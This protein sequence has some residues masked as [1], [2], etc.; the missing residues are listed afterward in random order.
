MEPIDHRLLLDALP[1]AVLLIDGAGYVVH[2]NPVAGRLLG[3]APGW[4]R[5]RSLEELGLPIPDAAAEEPI[6]TLRL[7]G[8][9][10]VDVEW[11]VA[12]I[13]PNE[14]ESLTLV[15]LCPIDSRTSRLPSGAAERNAFLAEASVLLASALDEDGVLAGLAKLAVPRLA[16]WCVF[17]MVAEDG[18]ARRV[19]VT[20]EAS[21]PRHRAW[22]RELE[23]RYPLNLAA[24]G[25]PAVQVIRTGRVDLK[26]A[27]PDSFLA[28]AARDENH[29]QILRGLGIASHVIVPLT[30][31]GRILG[32]LTLV[33]AESGRRYG[34]DDLA[35]AED[36]AQRAAL[37]VDNAR[38]YEAEQ[39]ARQ[40][41][42]RAADRTARLQAVTA[43]LA[44]GLTPAEVATAVVVEGVAALGARAGSIALLRDGEEELEIA[45]FAGY[46]NELID[47]WR[48]FP[49][50]AP[51]PIAEAVRTGNAVWI[52]SLDDLARR[53][54]NLVAS[55]A[56]TEDQ[57]RAAI[58][59]MIDG[60]IIGAMGLSFSTVR[61]FDGDDRAFALTLA[62]QCAQGL[63]RARLYEVEQRA[64][65]AA[66]AAE[67]Q[68]LLLAEASTL[69]A[70][71]LDYETTLTRVAGLVVPR[72]ADW[73]GIHI[74]EEDGSLSRLAVAHV[75]PTKVAWA[76]ELQERYP[77]DLDAPSGFGAV[78]RNG[79]SEVYRE[80]SDAMLVATARD[81]EHLAMLRRIGFRSVMIVPLVTRGRT[82]GVMTLVS[83]ESG[84]LFDP[85]DLALAEALAHRAAQAVD[86]ARLYRQARAA[87]QRQEEVLAQLDTFLATA[88]IGLAF[89]DRDRRFVRVNDALAAMNGLPATAHLG[90]PIGEVLPSLA[91]TLDTVIAAVLTTGEPATDILT[92]SEMAGS[93]WESGHWLASYYPVRSDQGG[94]EILGVG[95][96]VTDVTQRKREEDAVR[97]MAEAST[98][99]AG[100]LD[101]ATTLHSIARLAV[102]HLADWCIV[103]MLEADGSIRRVEVAAADPTGSADA[104][105]LA[106]HPPAL[107][108]NAGVAKVL[109]TG[110]PEL[111]PEVPEAFLHEV[112]RDADHLAVLRRVGFRSYMGVPLVARGRIL[113]ALNFISTRPGR[114]Y[115]P[116]DLALA[117]D[118][119]RRAA[120][121]VDNARL[122]QEQ[123]HALRRVEELAAERALVLGQIADGVI[124]TDSAGRI[125]FVNEAARHIHGLAVLGVPVEEY[126]ETYHLL[127]P[128]GHPY[129][130]EELP[131]AR[132]VRRG[133]TTVGAEWRIHRPDRT[134][135]IAEGSAAPVVTEDGTQLG[136][137]L[138][139]R[140][141]TAQREFERQKDDFV[142]TA[143]HDLKTPLTTIKGWAQ[144]L[145]HRLER[146]PS[147]VKDANAVAA[148]RDQ[149]EAMQHLIEQLLAAARLQIGQQP[150][151]HRR[152][153]D[154]HHLAVR[155]V[156]QHQP[157]TDR[158]TLRVV[159]PGPG[160]VVGWWDPD[161]VSQIAGNLL[162][163][164]IKYSPDGGNVDIIVGREGNRARLGVRDQ[165]IGI[166]TAALARV[167]ERSY[168]VGTATDARG[169]PIEGLG[170]G[171][172][173]A[174]G[175]ATRL[176]GRIEVESEEGRG[177][178]FSLVLPLDRRS[179]RP[180][181]NEGTEAST[182]T[183]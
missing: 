93:P 121:A 126:S 72:I 69:L 9:A 143:S 124:T 131:L 54:P 127:T 91:P 28:Q 163:N 83:A 15:T 37:A 142:L 2:A 136:A 171:L 59:L 75:D 45:G 18:S 19:V 176:G 58:P 141:V 71:S 73:C 110:R 7:P 181:P 140:D 134:E 149:A 151:V 107:D 159:G 55:P 33:A 57:A 105:Q 89:L 66:E 24:E 138:T 173:S 102:A 35:L 104:A 50:A 62:G 147:R 152:F 144:L 88:P 36:L 39:R 164:A 132:A 111:L 167:F 109:Q 38:L 129:P 166:P 183:A 112:A 80:I 169:V 21:D 116:A 81:Q 100:S 158:H 148:I 25:N 5:G 115:S 113:G 172:F 74:V 120:L 34:R 162:S 119:A 114:H 47:A 53:F 79:R 1:D 12:P 76:R 10:P 6:R 146:D 17:D 117:E 63:E 182:P 78:L 180:I 40:A 14:G 98:L 108:R 103:D 122:Y 48:R 65:I 46:P 56:I 82:L 135:V 27:F 51:V 4:L 125:I 96:V 118:L 44:E 32:A 90:R 52:E 87:I 170:L 156:E 77:P 43:A 49:V 41:A 97:F 177:S 106:Q 8:R 161:L 157:L 153:G 123:V 64:R 133:E 86:N 42:E 13:A 137:V 3:A 23:D 85:D 174:Q 84:R 30:A 16:D 26:T 150:A 11:T 67:Q 68:S 92:S 168:R 139:L 130:P 94:G 145:Q 128:A 95:A 99:L 154:L 179:N 165:G 160:A 101:Y 178:T 61:V 22:A 29:L 175:L 70:G 60:R 31:R 20:D 155:L